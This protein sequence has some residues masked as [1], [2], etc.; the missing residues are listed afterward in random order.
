M[1]SKT[2][3]IGISILILLM[4]FLIAKNFNGKLEMPIPESNSRE[5]KSAAVFYPQHQ[6]DEVLWG[7]SA[8]VDAIKQCGVNNVYVV[9]VSDGSG[10]NV[11]KA[12]TKF[13]NLTRKQKEELRNNEFKSALRELG[14]KPQNVIILADIDKKEG[15]HYELM[16]KII[17]D[18]EHKFK[19]DVTHIAHHYKY[20]DHI[21]HRKN[22]EVLKKLKRERKIKDDLYFI[23]PKYVKY[24]PRNERAI[25]KVMD[26]NDY[27]KVKSACYEYKVVNSKRKMYG[28]GYIS[29][30]SYF[31][32]LLDD[33]ELTSVLGED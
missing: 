8:I 21:M 19:G 17:L 24:I 14:V 5:F 3:H 30:H 25:Y 7:G 27:N 20:D 2:K 18:F 31:E 29:A 6:D 22:G 11:F 1:E 23:K 16:E 15:T 32:H 28:I 10:V 33:P 12:N 4:I 9:L 13:R 26:F